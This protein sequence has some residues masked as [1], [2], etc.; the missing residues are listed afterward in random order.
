MRLKKAGIYNLVNL[1][2]LNEN[3]YSGFLYIQNT[4]ALKKWM[5]PVVFCTVKAPMGSLAS[6]KAF[7]FRGYQKPLFLYSGFLY[8]YDCASLAD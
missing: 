3:L 4:V 2:F 1:Q 5:K 8:I 7:A 6:R